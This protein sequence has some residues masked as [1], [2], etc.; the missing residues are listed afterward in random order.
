M[1][2]CQ[3]NEQ[4]H[5]GTIVLQPNRSWTWRA[6]THFVAT[7]MI[8]S[9]AIAISFT[10]RGYW[11][12]LPFTVIEL[13]VLLGCLYYCVRRTHTTEVITLSERELIYECGI[14]RPTERRSFDRYF[15]RFFVRKPQHP[16]YCKQIALRCRG[17]EFEVGRFLSDEEKDDL[18]HHLRRII[19]R[20]DVPPEA[21]GNGFPRQ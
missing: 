12:V 18:V 5:I 20:L 14:R 13:S 2:S 4:M 8:L 17:E 7:L 21:A 6:N 11:V 3:F 19:Q 10:W 15:S 9:C 16:W 1:I